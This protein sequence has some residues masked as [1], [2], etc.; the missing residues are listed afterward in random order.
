MKIL[1][2]SRLDCM[3]SVSSEFKL[4]TCSAGELENASAIWKL[5]SRNPESGLQMLGELK[6]PYPMD[7]LEF[8]RNQDKL[9]ARLSESDVFDVQ[10]KLKNYDLL[11][12]IFRSTQPEFAD[13]EYSFLFSSGKWIPADV[14][15]FERESDYR[16]RKTGKILDQTQKK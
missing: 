14:N 16:F 5:F 1:N 6:L 8:I 9:L 12:F 15:Y 3:C 11:V 13:R 4:C 2:L 10:P 7:P